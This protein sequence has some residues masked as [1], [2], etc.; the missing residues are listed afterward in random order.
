MHFPLPDPAFTNSRAA[1]ERF[2]L[3]V[4][5]SVGFVALLWLI[6]LL[7]WGLDLDRFGVRPRETIGVIGI[8][9]APLLHA[10]FAHLV[11]NTLPLLILGTT[12]LHLYPSS[13][14]RV[15]PAIYLVP[16]V[17]VWLF[18]RGGNHIGASGL[19]YGLVAYIFFAGMFRGDRRAM[20]ASLLVAFLYGAS[21]W[22]VLPLED[23][24]SWETHLAAALVGIVMAYIYRNTD[25]SPRVEY[26]W[27]REAQ[28][29]ANDPQADDEALPRAN[30]DD[31]DGE[32][33]AP[34]RPRQEPLP[35]PL[36]R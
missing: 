19:V 20:S 35:D 3:A 7:G 9:T 15:L 36:D 4:K 1:R 30:A 10:G 21:V 5:L 24:V 22:G 11:A 32:P 25:V 31:R 14:L 16:G 29:A 33:D 12:M 18:A 23:G 6:P 17:A 13:A 8:F 2:H 28:E 27:E 34:R 26:S